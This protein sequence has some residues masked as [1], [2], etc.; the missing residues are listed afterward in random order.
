MQLKKEFV[1]FQATAAEKYYAQFCLQNIAELSELHLMEENQP[2]SVR[3]FAVFLAKK[4]VKE[5]TE[6]MK[7]QAR[8]VLALAKQFQERKKSAKH[9]API[10]RNIK[11][12]QAPSDWEENAITAQLEEKLKKLSMIMTPEP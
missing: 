10:K 7:E 6:A 11:K 4:T 2:A 3:D 8:A 1:V 12:P 9:R 5:R